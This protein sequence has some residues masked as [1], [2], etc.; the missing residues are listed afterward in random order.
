VLFR[1]PF[2]FFLSVQRTYSNVC[3]LPLSTFS[4]CCSCLGHSWQIPLWGLP[5]KSAVQLQAFLL[6]AN[7]YPFGVDL[8]FENSQVLSGTKLKN[9]VK[10]QLGNSI[11]S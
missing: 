7:F 6:E 8:Q 11:S 5:L 1:L 3:H 2:P 10:T 4:C 9:K